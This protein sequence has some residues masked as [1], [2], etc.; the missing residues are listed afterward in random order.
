MIR[1]QYKEQ[2]LKSVIENLRSNLASGSLHLEIK[3][4]AQQKVKNC[5]IVWQNGEITYAGDRIPSDL[6][7]LK[8]IGQKFKPDVIDAAIDLAKKKRQIQNLFENWQIGW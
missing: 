2:H 7:L 5:I 4:E 8:K 1:H 3:I 6:E